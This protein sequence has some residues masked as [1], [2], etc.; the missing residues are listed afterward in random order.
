M[1]RS[2]V[3][4]YGAVHCGWRYELGEKGKILARKFDIEVSDSC[5]R[6]M[7]TLDYESAAELHRELE[8]EFGE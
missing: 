3:E 6:H 8:Q 5:G 4:D 2:R 7:V 1:S